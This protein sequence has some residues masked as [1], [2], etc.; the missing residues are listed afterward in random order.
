MWLNTFPSVSL[1]F[2]S[3]FALSHTLQH[4]SDGRMK[5]P[6]SSTGPALA[7]YAIVAY[8]KSI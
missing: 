1:R 6:F 8:L 2:S 5:K 4:S 3:D 7:S